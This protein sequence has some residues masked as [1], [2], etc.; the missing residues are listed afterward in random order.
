MNKDV[1]WKEIFSQM[2]NLCTRVVTFIFV[3]ATIV[4]A[5]FNGNNIS[6]SLS[7]IWSIIIIGII[8]GLAFIIFYIPNQISKKMMILLQFLYF[9]VLNATVLLIGFHQEWFNSADKDSVIIMEVMFVLVYAGVSVLVWSIDF[10]QANK[11][12][13]LLQK[14]KNKKLC[15]E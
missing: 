7:D 15:A 14:R 5:G 3:I 6:F 2:L 11:M 8:S 12:N 4:T 9:V 1:T 10:R 13:K